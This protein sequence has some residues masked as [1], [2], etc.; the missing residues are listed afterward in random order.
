MERPVFDELFKLSVGE[1]N[2]KRAEAWDRWT[3]DSGSTEDK[4]II[5]AIDAML[6]ARDR[7]GLL[8]SENAE[9]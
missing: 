4:K 1:L 5:T 2:Q 9:A 6:K 8:G 7:L 3:W